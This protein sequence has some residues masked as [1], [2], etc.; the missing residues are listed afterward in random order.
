MSRISLKG[1]KEPQIS[2]P[3]WP[4]ESLDSASSNPKIKS[5]TSSA[6]KLW[7][8]SPIAPEI[9][10]KSYPTNAWTSSPSRRVVSLSNSSTRRFLMWLSCVGATD[11]LFQ[12]FRHH[13]SLSLSLTLVSSAF[14]NFT[15]LFTISFCSHKQKQ[16]LDLFAC[17]SR[18]NRSCPQ[19]TFRYEKRDKT[20]TISGQENERQRD[21]QRA[22]AATKK[23]RWTGGERE[24]CI[25]PFM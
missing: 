19:I 2:W 6:V 18:I 8:R 23:D 11:N 9:N 1:T 13:R 4:N 25:A 3:F 15:P 16:T 17:F 5:I 22:A 21:C 7:S 10:V 14:T 12:L 20:V 24:V